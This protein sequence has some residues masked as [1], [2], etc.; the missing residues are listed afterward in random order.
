MVACAL[1]APSGASGSVAGG[2]ATCTVGQ[3]VADKTKPYAYEY[4]ACG[5]NSAVAFL[6][7]AF[8]KIPATDFMR[9]ASPH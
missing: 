8:F 9:A 5:G 6:V 2:R 7:T 4:P 1:E 3:S